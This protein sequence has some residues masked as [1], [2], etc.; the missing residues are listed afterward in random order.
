MDPVAVAVVVLVAVAVGTIAY[1]LGSRNRSNR[2]ATSS[3]RDETR[4]EEFDF[5]PFFTNENG[6]V[7]FDPELFS[8]GVRH[9]LETHNARAG[10]ELIV[11]GEQNLVRNTLASGA[12]SDYKRLYEKYDGDGVVTDNDAYLDNYRRL[13]NQVGR[14]FP[15]TGIEILL[16]NLVNPSKSLVAI[17]NGEVTGRSVG[18]GATNLVL[19]LKTRKQRGEDKVNYELNIGARRFKCTTMPIFRPDY[20]LVGAICINVDSNFIREVA[21]DPDRVDAFIDN[22]LRTD[23]QLDENILSKDEYRLAMRGKRHF[24]EEAI[25]YSGSGRAERKLQAIYFSDIVDF[26]SLMG[27]DETQTLQ[28]VEENEAIHLRAFS[29]HRGRLLKR[30]GDGLLAS[31]DTASGA[32]E[33]AVEV[34]KA[35]AQD[36]R[37]NIRVGI[38]LGEIVEEHGDVHGAGVNIASR[39][40][41][42]VEPGQVGISSVVYDNI[43]NKGGTTAT[44]LGQTALKNVDVPITLYTLDI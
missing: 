16:H 25:R 6:H 21:L 23:F 39:I 18:S 29:D 26:T 8:T 13:V 3:S 5:Y 41:T 24:M 15:N 38:H 40:Q 30:L 20:G 32:V 10:R 2:G 36:G 22:L 12:L 17:E 37:F 14:S 31:F 34:M 44:S 9:L 43:R 7:E 42:V 4:L 27:A 28:I 11:I 1:W 35:V 33:C 19:D